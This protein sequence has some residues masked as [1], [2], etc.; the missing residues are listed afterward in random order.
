MFSLIIVIVS[1]A[2]V[3]LLA[4][5]T[6]YY[7]GT[8]FSSSGESANASRVLNESQ[9]LTGAATVYNV[10]EGQQLTELADLVTAQYLKSIPQGSWS[11]V[12]GNVVNTGL[13]QNQCQQVNQRLGINTVPSC[14]DPAFVGREVCCVN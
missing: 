7:G 10:R 3:A 14:S 2:L 13:T 11:L 6:I 12:E 5:A 4:V 1:I 9:Q 8:A